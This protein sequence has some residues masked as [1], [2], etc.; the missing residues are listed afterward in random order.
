MH[1]LDR[2]EDKHDDSREDQAG[3]YPDIPLQLNLF[4]VVRLVNVAWRF[5]E[6]VHL[7]RLFR[8]GLGSALRL[9]FCPSFVRFD[10]LRVENL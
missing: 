3:S 7:A 1:P 10:R 8:F 9:R 4:I 2:R 5:T 6:Q